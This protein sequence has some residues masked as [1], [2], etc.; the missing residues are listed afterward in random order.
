MGWLASFGVAI[1]TAI[2]TLFGAG[3]VAGLAADWHS[4]SNFEGAV[5]F[6]VVGMAL[7]GGMAGFVIGLVTSRVVAAKSGTP[8]SGNP[9][10]PRFGRSLGL[11]T[12]IVTVVLALIAG[13]SYLLA[14]IP[15]EIDGEGLILIAEIR[16][17]E[18]P[19]AGTP[20]PPALGKRPYLMLGALSGMTARKTEYGPAFVEDARQE[21]GRWI[22]TGAVPIF[23]SRGS[24]LLDFG[25]N[26]KSIA[27][28][29]IP[30]PST[31]GEAHRQWSAWMPTTTTGA[32]PPAD[33][34][35]YR[36]K[37]IKDS[38]AVR[39]E[40]FGAFEVDTIAVYFYDV[41]ESD[42]KAAQSTFRVRYKGQ[43]VPGITEADT[44]AVIGGGAA[45]EAGGDGEHADGS[46]SR[47][48][49][50][51]GTT[52]ASESPCALLIDDGGTV[53]VVRVIGCV[54]P[55]T[56]RLMP[57]Q[58]QPTQPAAAADQAAPAEEEGPNE[59]PARQPLPGWV[60]RET[61][62][63]PGLYRVNQALV[64]TRTLTV[65]EAPAETAPETTP[66]AAPQ[67]RP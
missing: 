33:Q 9:G 62:A 63:T 34:F 51:T 17:P 39:T 1:L 6:F 4:M 57:P 42:R 61:F 32:P 40:T 20:V 66:E 55:T 24:R 43:P 64:D 10:G 31:P 8:G 11:S 47:A 5:G 14:D 28:F 13:T 60:D 38:E 48:L 3:T 67:A 36:Y 37:V 22:V 15:P 54:V 12:G 59:A 26:N 21:N 35:T 58:G 25:A 53:R 23:T 2:L 46:A 18:A 49:F 27:G 30:L 50:L 52:P 44:A 19:K 45:G 56:I 29:I 7:V 41:Q 65:S 16:W